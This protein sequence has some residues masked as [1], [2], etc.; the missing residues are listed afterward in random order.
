MI[1][2]DKISLSRETGKHNK[3]Q[4]LL[5]TPFLACQ[6]YVYVKNHVYRHLAV[7]VRTSF[8]VVFLGF[9]FSSTKRP[10]ILKDLR[11]RVV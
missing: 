3:S 11:H 7:Y 5:S 9:L 6:N 4:S 8:P 2:Y 10:Y 1:K